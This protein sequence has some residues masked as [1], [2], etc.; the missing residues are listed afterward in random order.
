MQRLHHLGFSERI[1]ARPQVAAW[2][3]RLFEAAGFDAGVA[4][5]TNPGY[6]DIFDRERPAACLRINQI[7]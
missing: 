6:V 5:W 1:E 3:A 4:R 2:A 7:A